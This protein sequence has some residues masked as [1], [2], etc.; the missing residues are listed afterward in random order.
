MIKNEIKQNKNKVMYNIIIKVSV[1]Y[2]LEILIY[3][4]GLLIGIIIYLKLYIYRYENIETNNTITIII[5]T[6]D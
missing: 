2:L 1:I 6:D 3:I 5:K 4:I